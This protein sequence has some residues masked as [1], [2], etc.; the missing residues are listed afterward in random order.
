MFHLGKENIE[1]KNKKNTKKK[2]TAK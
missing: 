1:K 2:I